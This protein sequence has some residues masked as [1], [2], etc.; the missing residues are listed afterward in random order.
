MMETKNKIGAL[1]VLGGIALLG[2]Y[3]F[4]KN[5]PNVAES[6]AKG[7]QALSNYY[8]TGVGAREE[9]FIP[10]GTGYVN[11]N[12]GNISLAQI[13]FTNL[14]PKQEE[15]I[16]KAVGNIVDPA[17]MITEQIAN[18]LANKDF[19]NEFMGLKFDNIKLPYGY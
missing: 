7:L 19:G 11:P 14:T 5:K 10:R 18:N 6:Q 17:T 4:K 12:L 13:D 1:L 9:T 15:D 8:S 16:K 3:Y 2:V